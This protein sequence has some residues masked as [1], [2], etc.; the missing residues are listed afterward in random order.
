M[1]QRASGCHVIFT[2]KLLD[3]V[4]PAQ[5][6]RDFAAVFK[7]PPE[8]AAQL[9]LDGREK[10]LKK[11]VEPAN[12]ERYRTVLL[13]MGI[14]V[15]ITSNDSN[16]TGV[17]YHSNFDEKCPKCGAEQVQNGVCQGCGILIAQYRA[18]HPQHDNTPP[19]LSL[20][21]PP[22]LSLTKPSSR[23]DLPNDAN[24]LRTTPQPLPFQFGWQ[25]LIIAWQRFRIAPWTWIGAI[26]LMLTLTVAISL[27]PV[28]GGLV[29][30]LLAPVFMG[31][32]MVGAQD[33]YNGQ[34][35]KLNHLF[36]GFNYHSG[37]LMLIGVF[38]LLGAIII[39]V[40]AGMLMALN[41]SSGDM[42]ALQQNPELVIQTLWPALALALI[43]FAG[44]HMAYWFAPAL[45]TLNDMSPLTAMKL[46]FRACLKN[47]LPYTVFVA[48][49]IAFA[50]GLIA[51]FSV[52]IGIIVAVLQFV[53][54]DV[55]SVVVMMLLTSVMMIPLLIILTA[56][57]AILIISAHVAYRSIFYSSQQ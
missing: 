49:S 2:G 23:S 47:W 44:L 27:V 42:T 52:L 7:V 4:N 29:N 17:A 8:K 36:T 46:S 13:E 15:R 14:E 9:I 30:W 43:L 53:G 48:V 10:I 41:V 56:L 24:E 40:V 39:A 6:A 18:M 1:N 12:A 22:T 5:A 57:L 33:Q 45:V 51:V 3:G 38:Y 21:T 11:D 20:P 50:I 54:L 16:E 19:Q 55:N 37:R 35:F 31:G 25:W 34:Q 26:L 28:I 32:L